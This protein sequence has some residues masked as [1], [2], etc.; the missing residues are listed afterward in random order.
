[1]N[2]LIYVNS[3]LSILTNVHTAVTQLTPGILSLNEGGDSLYEYMLILASHK[4]NPLIA[5][6]SKLRNILLNV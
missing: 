5:P 3:I 6:P 2:A 4:V 1:M